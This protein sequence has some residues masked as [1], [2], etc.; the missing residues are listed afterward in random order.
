MTD[1]PNIEFEGKGVSLRVKGLKPLA[2]VTQYAAD[3]IGIIGEPL[4]IVKD[5][6]AAFRMNQA[7]ASAIAMQRAKEIKTERGELPEPVSQ[8]YL[9]SWIEGSSNEDATAE[10]ILE[11]WARLLANS[12]TE[13]DAKFLAYN[14]ALRKIG[15]KEAKIINRFMQP[16]F[17]A[18]L[19]SVSNGDSSRWCTVENCTYNSRSLIEFY[20]DKIEHGIIP[21]PTAGNHKDLVRCAKIIDKLLDGHFISY[22]I[23]NGNSGF[24]IGGMDG[25]AEVLEHAGLIKV[26]KATLE[27]DEVGTLEIS[28]GVPTAIG[29]GLYFEINKDR[30]LIKKNSLDASFSGDYSTPKDRLPANLAKL[31]SL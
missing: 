23:Y 5:K 9:A 31:L 1:E 28:W 15:P 24:G 22:S 20:L 18:G 27:T 19:R 10:N 11:L 12:T 25:A 29:L 2:Q 6:L 3:T 16:K 8:K 14:D 21:I 13:F 4:G 30:L 26:Q 17:I 7:E